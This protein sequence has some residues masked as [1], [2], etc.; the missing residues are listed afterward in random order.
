MSLTDQKVLDKNV[1]E[2]LCENKI[3]KSKTQ[4]KSKDSAFDEICQEFTL[5]E[6]SWNPLANAKRA[7]ILEKPFLENI[8]EEKTTSLLKKY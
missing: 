1:E 3:N 5:R 6:Y 2:L 8:Y 4:E 7:N